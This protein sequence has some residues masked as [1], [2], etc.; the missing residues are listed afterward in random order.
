MMIMMMMAV[1]VIRLTIITAKQN[2]HSSN[3]SNI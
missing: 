1:A 2:R 3:T